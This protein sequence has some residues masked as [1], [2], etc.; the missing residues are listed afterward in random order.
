MRLYMRIVT[1]QIGTFCRRRSGRIPFSVRISAPSA[2]DPWEQVFQGNIGRPQRDHA[3]KPL[4]D[5]GGNGWQVGGRRVYGDVQI[6][7]FSRGEKYPE[8][9][10]SEYSLEMEVRRQNHST[11]R[12]A[13]S[14][15]GRCD[16]AGRDSQ[17][18]GGASRA[19]RPSLR[20][21]F[22]AKAVQHIIISEP[23]SG[24]CPRSGVHLQSD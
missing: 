20:E 12:R 5:G 3:R 11:R 10:L 21:R 14:R 1:D 16:P 8:T 19:I 15:W 7:L 24:I 9:W 4:L 18:G 13:S 2:K 6:S 17:C 23:Q 22:P